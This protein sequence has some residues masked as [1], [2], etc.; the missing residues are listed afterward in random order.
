MTAGSKGLKYFV[1]TFGCQMNENDSEHIAGI[2]ER[3]GA[4]EAGRPEDADIIVV[5]TCAVREKS[6]E[7]LRSY[8]GRLASLKKRRD[9]L[10]GVAG[11]VAQVARHGLLENR[12]YIDFVIGPANYLHLPEVLAKASEKPCVRTEWSPEWQE[13]GAGTAARKSPASTFVPIMEGCDNF[14][15]YC[16]VPFTR[17]RE[18]SRPSSSVLREVGELAA[19]GTREVLLLG[20]NVNSYRD[21]EN[22]RDFSTLLEEVCAVPGIE[23]VRFLTSHPKDLGDDIIAAMQRN[24]RICRQLHL[25]LQSGS[26]AVLERMNRGYGRED[27]LALAA[28]LQERLPGIFLSTDVIVGFPGESDRDFEETCDVLRRVRF[29]NVFSFRFSPRPLTSAAKL[30][31]DVPLEVKRRRLIALQDLQKSIQLEINGTFVGRD[32]RVL[33]HG[34]SVKGAGRFAGRSEGGQIVNFDAGGDPTGRFIDV[35]I[36]GR[37]PYSLHGRS[38]S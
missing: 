10:I 29:A 25:P 2:L 15:S 38:A 27:Y 26:S 17:G 3:E 37:G 30:P 11:C 34:A 16:I 4:A 6:E 28:R 31:D 36:T 18:K 8:L 12:P 32:L 19:S 14:C 9:V 21:P 33:C 5:N 24:A 35:H 23:W 1:R 7:K 22:A 13:F 20:Q